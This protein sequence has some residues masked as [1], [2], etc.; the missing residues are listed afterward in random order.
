MSRKFRLIK[1]YPGSPELGT[2]VIKCE[3]NN[4]LICPKDFYYN[5]DWTI[6]TSIIENN[7]EFWDEIIE[8]CVPIGTKFT[9]TSQDD[10]EIYTIKKSNIEGNVRIFSKD[11]QYKCFY[12]I[13]CVNL[14]F[15][16]GFWKVY[17][18]PKE[19]EILSFKDSISS[20]WSRESENPNASF[21]SSFSYATEEILLA[22]KY[23]IHSIKRLS[24]GKIFTVG[25]KIDGKCGMN[26]EIVKIDTD[27]IYYK[28]NNKTEQIH[29]YR[30]SEI[31]HSKIPL[32]K[33][34]DGVEIY[35]GDTYYVHFPCTGSIY[36]GYLA[37]NNSNNSWV[38]PYLNFSTREAAENYILMNKPCLS[39]KE[40]TPIIGQCNNTT[41]IDL[42]KLTDKLK[43][44]V[45]SKI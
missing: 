5:D 11:A 8:L 19:Y 44:L 7:P 4:H 24:D 39:I 35:E 23:E 37:N 32:F 45:K 26:Q 30:L 40:I 41:Y 25:D 1:K 33:T 36:G 16:K 6:E 27:W 15:E 9:I 22:R 2:V 34:E 10:T 3:N 14:F 12:F 31:K 21:R 28:S 29:T 17:E 13:S 43:E 42:D 18:E 20:I 38:S